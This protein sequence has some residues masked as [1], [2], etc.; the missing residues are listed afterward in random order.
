MFSTI[1]SGTKS[2]Y[3]VWLK[4]RGKWPIVPVARQRW[5]KMCEARK[6]GKC[7]AENAAGAGQDEARESAV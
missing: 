5:R 3:L 4:A 2:G 7:G 6:T 1:G